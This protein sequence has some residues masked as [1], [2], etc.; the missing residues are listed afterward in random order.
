MES[1]EKSSIKNGSEHFPM[2]PE[3]R[4]E[5]FQ[6]LSH[7]VRQYAGIN[8]LDGKQ[9]LVKARLNKRVR[10]L[11]MDSYQ[12]YLSFLQRDPEG[13]ELVAMLDAISTNVTNFFRESDHFEFLTQTFLPQLRGRKQG[14][15]RKIRI[16][17]AGC[18]SGEEPYTLAMVLKRAWP[19]LEQFDARILATDLSTRV[20]NSAREGIYE[21]NRLRDIP[22]AFL[23]E[24]F[25]PLANAKS[26]V[27]QVRRD[28][29]NLVHFARLN[30]LE[31]WPMKGP[32]DAI[33]CRNVM[34]Y[35]EKDLREVLVGKYWNLL[36][37]G[38]ILFIGH[39]ESLTG[40][41]HRFEYL[42]PTIYRK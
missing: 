15:D 14:A 10:E 32:F 33:F 38:G 42:A 36:G 23:R 21:E 11:G 30:L 39:S 41:N 26:R 7:L 12:E 20:L 31:D 1:R 4:P 40:I 13:D 6:K 22:P 29:R 19:D 8:L 34:I 5:D 2:M 37:P 35:F 25:S 3:L 24:Y 27:F 17:S 18:S 9:E 28:L 16:W